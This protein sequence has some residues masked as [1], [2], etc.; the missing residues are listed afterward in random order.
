MFLA[1]L[2]ELLTRKG[3]PFLALYEFYKLT[4]RERHRIDSFLNDRDNQ[5]AL[6]DWAYGMVGGG[7]PAAA[8]LAFALAEGDMDEVIYR[9][10]IELAVLVSQYGML[11]ALNSIQGPKYAMSF[12][13]M[14]GSLG[15]ARGMIVRALWPLAPV[16]A[17]YASSE[18]GQSIAELHPGTNAESSV[19]LQWAQT[20][21][22]GGGGVMP[23]VPSDGGAPDTWFD[24]G[25]WWEDL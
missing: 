12:H 11:Q 7:V 23:V 8:H 19:A 13:R 10:K 1:R 5:E 20:G 22:T 21:N 25:Q 17:A 15:A 16:V 6:L 2:V 3:D 9:A 24:F 18:I 14:H 4:W